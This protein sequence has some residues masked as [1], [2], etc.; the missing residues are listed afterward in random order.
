[1][2]YSDAKMYQKW[3]DGWPPMPKKVEDIY[4]QQMPPT[5]R[6]V[7]KVSAEDDNID[8]S[9]ALDGLMFDAA[10]ADCTAEVVLLQLFEKILYIDSE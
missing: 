7:V 10:N 3:V 1:M 2:S 4:F 6:Q 8:S 9:W 5:P